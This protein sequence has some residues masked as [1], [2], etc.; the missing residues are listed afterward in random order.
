MILFVLFC[1][2]CYCIP[3]SC[4]CKNKFAIK[5]SGTSK[6]V[7][8]WLETQKWVF[9]NVEDFE[10]FALIIHLKAENKKNGNIKLLEVE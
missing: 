5:G 1:V 7:L 10:K 3:D 4:W 2:P 6:I 9:E 8:D